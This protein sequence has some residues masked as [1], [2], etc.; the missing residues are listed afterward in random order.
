MRTRGKILLVL[1]FV[2]LFVVIPCLV[3]KCLGGFWAGI[4]SYFFVSAVSG[5]VEYFAGRKKPC[6]EEMELEN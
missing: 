2:I 4:L 3:G 5:I 6:A 1:G